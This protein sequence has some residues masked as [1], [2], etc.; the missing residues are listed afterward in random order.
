MHY[1]RGDFQRALGEYETALRG[2][3][4]DAEI[5]SRIGYTHRR[6]GNW[7]QVY[8]AFEEAT[9]L[10]P[11]DATLFYDLGG[12]SFGFSRRYADAVRAYD[13]ASTL[14]PDLY[15][16]AIQRGSV[17][18]H[19]QGQ[20][21][22]LRAIVADL[23]GGLHL[24]EVDLARV[25][26]ALWERDSEGLL[27]LLETNPAPVFETQVAY[28]PK[29][30]YSGWAHRLRGDE[31]AA[32]AAFDSARAILEPMVPGS[33][34]D[35]RILIALGYVYAGLGRAT[36]AAD[37]AARAVTLRQEAGDALSRLRTVQAAARVLAQAGLADQALPHLERVLTSL[38]PVSVH[39]L[40]LDPLFD[41]IRDQ[42][43]FQSLLERFR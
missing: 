28:L 8:A 10:N 38:T 24:P 37:A 16:A 17:Y 12:H 11:R 1:V 30:I 19:W 41:P 7:P 2:L 9:R 25:N 40:N 22:T 36:E 3:P 27:D 29:P 5:V 34:N 6:L 13:R 23:P 18:L 4:N 31:S 32:L 14:A 15:D 26:L 43:A 39:T 20:M 42:P 21:D 35:E 33:P